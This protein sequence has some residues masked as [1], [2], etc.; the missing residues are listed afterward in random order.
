MGFPPQD[1]GMPPQDMGM[2]MPPQDM[3]MPPQGMPPQGM[4]PQDMGMGMPPQD[5]GFAPGMPPPGPPMQG[6]P[7]DQ[8]PM[9]HPMGMPDAG[10]Q[11][12][13][14]PMLGQP[15]ILP[16]QQMA[17][18]PQAP[19]PMDMAPQMGFQQMGAPQQPQMV[20]PP[21]HFNMPPQHMDPSFMGQP[22]QFG[23]QFGTQ[24]M[25]QWP[26]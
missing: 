12:A 14:D 22:H 5:M 1:M 21:Q 10:F 9:Q 13:T 2:G 6:M 11:Q 3:G 24:P 8:V 4:P 25:A 7:P 16:M 19:P 20:M 15:G 18:V 26:Q 17:G 23:D